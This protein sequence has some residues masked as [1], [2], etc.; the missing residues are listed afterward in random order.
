MSKI[1]YSSKRWLEKPYP[2]I[3]E[4]IRRLG[5][6]SIGQL[7]SDDFIIRRRGETRPI[8][9]M[10]HISWGDENAVQKYKLFRIDPF[11]IEK[12]GEVGPLTDMSD[13][14]YQRM[15]VQHVKDIFSEGEQN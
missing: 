7:D 8:F 10:L 14:V 1:T 13:E 9:Y 4:L 5:Y 6:A 11:G 15:K 3:G 2:S 12:F